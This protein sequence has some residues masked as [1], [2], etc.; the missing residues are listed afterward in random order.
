MT[1]SPYLIN[2]VDPNHDPERFDVT[3]TVG[4]DSTASVKGDGL[5]ALFERLGEW[6]PGAANASFDLALETSTLRECKVM[7]YAAGHVLLVRFKTKAELE[8]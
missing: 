1:R 4:D 5:P 3:V 7:Q 2:R 8:S 6:G